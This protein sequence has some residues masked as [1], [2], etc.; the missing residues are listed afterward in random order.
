MLDGSKDVLK[1][2]MLSSVLNPQTLGSAGLVTGGVL[3]ALGLLAN[4]PNSQNKPSLSP[5][6]A[7]TTVVGPFSESELNDMY[8]DWRMRVI[9]DN[10]AQAA[11]ASSRTWQTSLLQIPLFGNYV[12][13]TEP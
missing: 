6:G 1:Q 9:S 7:N 4:N 13:S 12:S 5:L 11:F 10:G 2:I 8:N 3:V